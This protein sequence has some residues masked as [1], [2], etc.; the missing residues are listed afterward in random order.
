MALIRG[1]NSA[2]PCPICLVH[3]DKLSDLSK[4]SELRTTKNM[5]D[6]YNKAQSLGAEAKETLL[7]SYGLRDIE[8]CVLIKITN[9]L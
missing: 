9:S 1:T 8:V 5:K 2:C 6:T 7:Q 3:N 4:L